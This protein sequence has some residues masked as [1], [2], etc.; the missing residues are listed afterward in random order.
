MKKHVFT[1]LESYSTRPLS[2]DRLIVSAFVQLN[3]LTIINKQF[4]KDYI[5]NIKDDDEYKALQEFISIINLE[6]R[7]F[8]IE[9]LIELFEFV[10]SPSDRI[11]NGAIYTPS[12]I[13]QYITEK[14]FSLL[15]NEDL[16]HVKI[17]DIACGCGG[18]LYTAAK[19]LKE[20]TGNSYEH[21]FANNIFGLDLQQ[22]SVDR[23]KLLL[24]LLAL[25]EGEDIEEFTFNIHQGDAL[26][27]N[28]ADCIPVYQGFDCILGNPPYVRYR[29]LDIQTRENVKLFEVGRSGLT[30]LYIP[31]FQIG[32]DNLLP[33][34]VLGYIT[35]NSFF[36]SLNGRALRTYYEEQSLKFIIEDFGAEQVFKAKNT[37]V[38]ICFIQKT[39]CESISYTKTS[40]SLLTSPKDYEVLS[41]K[42]LDSKKGWNLKNNRSIDLIEN[43][44]QRFGDLYKT[45]HGIATLKN[46]IY[47]FKPV[48][49]DEEF[50]YL[51]NGEKH[52][53][54]KGICRSIVNSNKLSRIKSLQQLQEKVI[55]P[56]SLNG[57]ADIIHENELKD[58]FPHA[59][60]Y[61]LH[62][63]E[64]LE[65]RDK[66][67]A[68]DYDNWYAF[69]RRQS[70]EKMAHKLFFPKFSDVSPSFLANDDENLLFYNGLALIGDDADDLEIA[71]KIMGSQIFWYYIKSTSKPY[72]GSYYS[73]NSAYINNFGVCELDE[74]EKEFLIKEDNKVL[75]N[76]FFEEKYKVSIYNL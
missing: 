6:L 59:Y 50:Y 41:Y 48:D 24:S 30:D 7:K 46:D 68:V 3:T 28:W 64:I 38:C 37:Y 52:A 63:K 26:K 61:L 73:L 17:S 66:G 49:E 11:V 19:I 20:Q 18:F 4:L 56:Y 16:N 74:G 53:I 42:I 29:N 69:G 55:F 47:I 45:R 51:Q 32:T 65:K 57:K 1:Y 58:N 70:L 76:E 54:E 10:I 21:I 60:K 36:K 75:L 43:T 72:S 12:H 71:R 34:G 62:K 33:N 15:E 25:S 23:A 40:E 35:M 39:F 8:D 27:F 5:I 31:F 67:K 14:S 13:R 9:A 22:Y 44:G 2:I